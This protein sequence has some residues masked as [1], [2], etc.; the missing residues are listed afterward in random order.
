[1]YTLINIKEIILYKLNVTSTIVIL[2]Y[3]TLKDVYGKVVCFLSSY[4]KNENQNKN[5]NMK[6]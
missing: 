1:M 3:I 5:N 4:Y 2:L 6:F